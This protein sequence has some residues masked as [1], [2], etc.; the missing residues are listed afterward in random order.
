VSLCIRE[1]EHARCGRVSAECGRVPL[2]C[3][4]MMCSSCKTLLGCEE[5][6]SDDRKCEVV[7]DKAEE[8]DI[9]GIWIACSA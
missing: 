1:G 5:P 7:L 2:E 6:E 9:V 8:D 4:S 3:S